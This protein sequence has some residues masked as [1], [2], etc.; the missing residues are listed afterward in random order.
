MCHSNDNNEWQQQNKHLAN[1]GLDDSVAHRDWSCN[2]CIRAELD[3][4]RHELQAQL[5]SIQQWQRRQQQI[6]DE[7]ELQEPRQKPPGTVQQRQ[8]Q[9]EQEL[10]Q[11]PSLQPSKAPLMVFPELGQPKINIQETLNKPLVQFTSEPQLTST[12]KANQNPETSSTKSSRRSL[13][14]REHEMRALE[15]RQS[16]EKKQ[17]EERLELDKQLLEADDSESDDLS[18]I[19]KIEEWLSKTENLGD[20]ESKVIHE[21]L[22]PGYTDISRHRL[23]LPTPLASTPFPGGKN[24]K[25]YQQ[26]QYELHESHQHFSIPPQYQST[27]QHQV[28]QLRLNQPPSHL[29]LL[30]S[31]RPFEVP[32]SADHLTARQIVKDLPR[33]GGDPEDWPRFIAAYERTVRMC[34]FRNDELLERLERSLFD[35]ALNTVKCLLLH[36]DNVPAIMSRLKTHF[37]NP[38]SIV[39]TMVK[40]VRL[41]TPP[42]E[43]KLETIIDFGLAVQNLCATIQACQL[44]E[45][46]YNVTLVSELIDSLPPS[47]QMQWALHSHE[48]AGSSLLDFNKWLGNLVEA[49]TKITKPK[50]L[51]KKAKREEAFLHLH[52]E[53]TTEEVNISAWDA[54]NG[55]CSE[56]DKCPKFRN[57]ST[58]S[59]WSLINDKKICRKCLTKHFKTCE[60]KVAC[61]VNGCNYLHHWLLHDDSK[62]KSASSSMPRETCNAHHYPVGGVLLKYIPVTLRGKGKSI[63][64]YAFFD[65]GSTC[66]LMEHSLY[67]DL[68]LDGETHPLCINWTGGHGRYEA[69]S[70]QCSVD[71]IGIRSPQKIFNIPKVHTVPSLDLPPQTLSVSDMKKSFHHLCNIPVDAYTNAKP[72]IL[73]GIDNVRL[74]HPLDSREGLEHEPT[75]VLTRLGWVIYGPC[76]TKGFDE[77][78]GDRRVRNY[79]ICQCDELHLA[80]K[81]FFSLD[82]LG[83]KSNYKETMSKDDERALM[84]LQ[85]N[86]VRAGR[87][88]ETCLL[89]RYDTVSLPDSKNMAKKRHSCLEKRLLREPATAAA[90]QEKILDY[91]SKGYIR[92]I[93]PKEEVDFAGR[94][95]YLPIFP[96]YN[97]NKPAKLRIVWDAAAKVGGVSLNSFLLKG[98]DQVKPLP[99]ILQRFREYRVAVTG[100]VREMFHQVRMNK[101]DQHCQRFLW[102]DGK[103]GKEPI[104]YLMQVMTF[105]ASCSPSS[106]QYVK[107]LNAKRFIEQYPAAVRAIEEDTYVDDMLISVET[108]E[109]AVV[110]S[111]AVRLIHADGGFEIRGWLSNCSSVMDAMGEQNCTQKSL[112]VSSELATEKILG[113]WW[114]TTNDCFT[115]KVPSRCKE[116]LL[117]GVEIPTKREVL[118][119]LMLIYDPLGLLA[120]VLM[121][122]KVLL[123]EIWRSGISWDSQITA[124]HFTKWQTWLSVLNQD[125]HSYGNN[126][127]YGLNNLLTMGP[128]SMKYNM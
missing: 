27:S 72:R 42:K 17:L 11:W 20:S 56:L 24:Q 99:S 59:R 23:D 49:L 113:M 88:Y 38:E 91:E 35:R 14:L 115:F 128:R 106:A 26:P 60:R 1:D 34:A 126:H 76:A 25:R 108:E 74:E 96:V 125:L 63:D 37:G 103:P 102:N 58:Q 48:T 15:V 101:E 19:N 117:S 83:I 6:A 31:Q 43:D 89:W 51:T 70:I 62:H 30:P 82:S 2:K 18:S 9:F 13:R 44:D 39:A 123:Q 50:T 116:E 46:L 7:K 93:S 40:R 71:I 29:Q 75:A 86:T 65:G 10:V 90:M 16:L 55:E 98:P 119:I 84:L 79:H 57:M 107:N 54:C 8:T 4:E 5:K 41:I 122:L 52:A 33:F 94:T 73:L 22:L 105:G 77:S 80:V 127:T 121:Y 81:N 111:K 47:L 36:P 53:Y 68:Q 45:R 104:V 32:L 112:D 100:D 69:G 3:K 109:E 120:N 118:R 85:S 114:N 92:K 78:A 110:L 64:T 97:P 61:N 95:W 67:E 66:T 124:A 12:K 21:T 28:P 87:S